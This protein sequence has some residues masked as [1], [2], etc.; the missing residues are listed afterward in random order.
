MLTLQLQVF[1]YTFSGRSVRV[2]QVH[3]DPVKERLHVRKTSFMSIESEDETEKLKLIMRWIMNK[4]MGKLKLDELWWNPEEDEEESS[5]DHRPRT[6]TK[7][8]IWCS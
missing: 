6:P 8:S 3:S 1:V 5:T 7:S 2:L 4:P